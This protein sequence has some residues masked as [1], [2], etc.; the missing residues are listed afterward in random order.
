MNA[1]YLNPVNKEDTLDT[2][3]PALLLA[4]QWYLPLSSILVTANGFV[5]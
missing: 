3:T 5:V 4:T 1:S 2:L